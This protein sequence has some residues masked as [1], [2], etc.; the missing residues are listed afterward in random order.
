M[1]LLGKTESYRGVLQDD[2]GQPL[3]LQDLLALDLDSR[4]VIAAVRLNKFHED[5]PEAEWLPRALA[6]QIANVCGLNSAQ[7]GRIRERMRKLDLI[8][9]KGEGP[10][11]LTKITLPQELRDLLADIRGERKPKPATVKSA[12]AKGGRKPAAKTRRKAAA[13]SRPAK[14]VEAKT[15]KSGVGGEVGFNTDAGFSTGGELFGLDKEDS[16]PN[17][18]RVLAPGDLANKAPEGTDLGLLDPEFMAE[19]RVW[20]ASRGLDIG[21]VNASLFLALKYPG[22]EGQRLTQLSDALA[23]KVCDFV[24][25]IVPDNDPE[26]FA[27]VWFRIMKHGSNAISNSSESTNK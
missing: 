19:N 5:N 7:S 4:S 24:R 2:H 11:T 18:R 15:T 10:G 21:A 9:T 25:S 13:K 26:L 16:S 6:T 17:E 1:S 22:V 20:M 12:G 3:D 14:P 8:A 27:L 23:A